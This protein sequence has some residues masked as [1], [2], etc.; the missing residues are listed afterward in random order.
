MATFNVNG[1][2]LFARQF[3]NFKD[4]YIIVGGTACS[5]VMN[6]VGLDFRATKDIDIIVT[7]EEMTSEFGACFWDFIRKG[8]YKI[9]KSND[10]GATQFFRFL[11]PKGG[12]YPSMIELFSRRQAFLPEHVGAKFTPIVIDEEISSLSAILLDDAY[13]SFLKSGKE[14][15]NGLSVLKPTHL[16]AFKAKAYVDLWN[17][18]QSGVHVDSKDIR[19]HRND[20]FR[21]TQLLSGDERV[22]VDESVKE[23]MRN[24]FELIR[25]VSVDMKTLNVPITQ[26][27]AVALLKKVFDI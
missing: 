20:V 15:I 12:S 6:D 18:N 7:V 16:I 22:E 21:L 13:Y 4:N 10:S 27:E 11:K 9:Y 25:S 19:K 1:L 23:D 5:L 17:K 8:D 26:G 14:I 3:E 24:F 2:D